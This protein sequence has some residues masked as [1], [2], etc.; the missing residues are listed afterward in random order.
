VGFLLVVA[1]GSLSGHVRH[2]L[3]RV[4]EVCSIGLSSSTPL[5]VLGCEQHLV[6]PTGGVED[7]GDVADFGKVSVACKVKD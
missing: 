4:E 7:G 5:E 2:H 6:D 1:D 3:R